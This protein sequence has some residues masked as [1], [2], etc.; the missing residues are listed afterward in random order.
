MF[1]CEIR[2]FPQFCKSDMSKYGYLEVFQRVPL[3]SRESTVF[4]LNHICLFYFYKLSCS[5]LYQ[6]I[7]C[8]YVFVSQLLTELN[9]SYTFFFNFFNLSCNVL[10]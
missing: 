8:I 5:E 1:I 4:T 2:F 7:Y 6:K 10:C 3:T 9:I